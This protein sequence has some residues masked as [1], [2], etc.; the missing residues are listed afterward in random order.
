MAQQTPMMQQYLSIKSEYKDAFLF[1]RLG[2]FYELFHEDAIQAAQLLEITLTKRGKGDDAIPMCGVPYHSA[3]SYID[4]I[5]E[6]GYK[7]AVCEQVEDP[8]E[9]KGVV[10]RDVVRVITPGTVMEGRALSAEENHYIA[11]LSFHKDKIAYAKSDLT[12]G[13]TEAGIVTDELVELERVLFIDG[14]KELIVSHDYPGDLKSWLKAVPF[15]VS[16]DDQDTIP[17]PLQSLYDGQDEAVEKAVGRVWSYLS[18]TQKRSLDHLQPVTVRMSQQ[19]M[20]MDAHTRRN[21]ELTS[22]LIDRT[23]KGTLFGLLDETKTA[24][25]SRRLRRWIESPL[26]HQQAIE[27]RLELVNKL[28]DEMLER[29]NIQDALQNVYDLERLVG[30]VAYGNVNARE[31]VQLKRS[32]QQAPSIFEAVNKLGIEGRAVTKE[33]ELCEALADHLQNALVDEPPISTKDGGMIRKGFHEQLDEYREANE[34]GKTWLSN[35]E[36]EERE[37][38]SIKTL[39]IGYNRVFGY[40][41]EVSRGQSHLVPDYFER[42]QTLTNAERYVTPELKDMERKILDAQ[43]KMEVLEYDLFVQIRE[44]TKAQITKIQQLAKVISYIDVL[45]GF[46]VVSENR[47]FTRPSFTDDRTLNLVNSRHPVVEVTIPAGD[48]VANDVHL[49]EEREMLLITGP[50]MAGKST[51]MRQVA[52]ISIMA[53]I[54]CYVPSD[55]AQLPRFDRIFTRIGAADD[56]VSGQSTFM[57][58]MVETEYALNQATNNSL[59]LLDEIGRGTSTYDGMALA[60]AIIEFIHERVRAKTLFSTHYHELTVLEEELETLDNVHVKAEEEDGNVVFLHRVEKGRADKS[61]GIHV[62][63]LASLPTEVTDRAETLLKTYESGQPTAPVQERTEPMP[64]EQLTLFEEPKRAEKVKEPKPTTDRE[65]AQLKEE[66]QQLDVLHLTPFEAL[67][68]LYEW[69][70]KLR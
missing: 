17:E 27:R 4:K 35:L 46:A 25:G 59:I 9:A 65:L 70:R 14:M 2:D 52:I 30:K 53:Q 18:E 3:E 67:E 54:G 26:Y 11:A 41:L 29:V 69:Q 34:N 36:R 8:R 31:L 28:K 50:N 39:K 23:K 19:F 13:E 64:D 62:A 43:E 37:K 24:M 10:K 12:T 1:F 16:F 38:S 47:R 57:V 60:Q 49:H 68:K 45:Q 44:T 22:S 6:K 61:Y 32:L 56:L 51:Y 55:T 33:A 21:L 58:E 5:I 7:I 42:K 20:Q 15:T 40:Y 48:Y 63:K 66:L